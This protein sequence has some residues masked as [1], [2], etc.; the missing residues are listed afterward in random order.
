[1]SSPPQGA[2]KNAQVAKA[3]GIRTRMIVWF[4]VLFLIAIIAIELV[5][6]LGLPFS[7]YEGRRFESSVFPLHCSLHR[8]CKRQDFWNPDSHC[9][10]GKICAAM[11]AS[12]RESRRERGDVHS[13]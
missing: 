11:P 9:R 8:G 10:Y 2:P 12:G 3:R 4:S 5:S 1:M 7:A 13:R 6:I